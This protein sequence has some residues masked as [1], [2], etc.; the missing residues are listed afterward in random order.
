MERR[1]RL[2]RRAQQVS[3]VLSV[4]RA[5]VVPLVPR[6]L[7][8]FRAWLDCRVQQDRLVRL[9]ALGP[10]VLPAQRVLPGLKVRPVRPVR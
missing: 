1:V 8:V 3:L 7:Q 9:V 10:R 2:V 5:P 4:Q 6:D